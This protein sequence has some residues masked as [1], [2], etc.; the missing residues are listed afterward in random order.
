MASAPMCACSVAV[1]VACE[2][3]EPPVRAQ[4]S[5]L[6][7]FLGVLFVARHAKGEPEQGAAVALDEN[8]KRVPVARKSQRELRGVPLSSA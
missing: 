2:T 8:A 6:H 7:H 4:K 1:A 5:F 3:V